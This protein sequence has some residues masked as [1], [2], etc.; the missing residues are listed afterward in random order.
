MSKVTML[1]V[2]PSNL[3]TELVRNE[4]VHEYNTMPQ[5]HSKILY[6][7]RDFMSENVGYSELPMACF[8]KPNSVTEPISPET[9]LAHLPI[10]SKDSV[11]FLLE[12]PS[13]M[14]VSVNF[15]ALLEA[16]EDVKA[17][18]HDPDELEFVLEAFKDNLHT[19]IDE[20]D[21][22]TIIFIPFLDK[23]KCKFYAKF[24]DRFE[25]EEMQLAGIEKVD[26]RQLT[27]FK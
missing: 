21:N 8:G 12:M 9:I 24:N 22:D 19:G 7:V 10:N 3:A 15:D 23:K 13:D 2:V 14:I 27:A 20:D 17:A 18:I 6:A 4:K 25:T 26:I 5:L 11:L 16:S 1:T